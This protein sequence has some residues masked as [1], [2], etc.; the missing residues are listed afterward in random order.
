MQSELTSASLG[1]HLKT[2][3]EL[4]WMSRTFL[5]REGAKGIPGRGQK[6]QRPRGGRENV[7]YSGNF[8]WV[9]MAGMEKNSKRLGWREPSHNPNPQMCQGYALRTLETFF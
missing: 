6:K 1:R 8:S 3:V 4:R 7:A 5:G 9:G 2:A